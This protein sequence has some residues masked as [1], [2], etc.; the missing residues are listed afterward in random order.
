MKV[1]VICRKEKYDIYVEMLKKGGFIICED[2]ELVFR[3]QDFNQDSIVGKYN[4][5]YEIISYQNIIFVEAFGHDV[6][7][8]SLEKEYG[9]K[10]KLFEIEGLFEAK[11][12]IR[13]SKSCVVNKH[14]IKEIRPAFN[15]KFELIMKNGKKLEVTRSYFNKFKEFIGF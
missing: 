8:H 3:E 11:G 2:A 12:F 6:I 10:E 15:T 9:I 14:Q 1:K 4:N 13:I 5:N 7:L